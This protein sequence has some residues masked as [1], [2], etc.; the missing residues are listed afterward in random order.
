[1]GCMLELTHPKVATHELVGELLD[2]CGWLADGQST[3][4]AFR[5]TVVAFEARKHQRLGYTLSSALAP[6]GLVQ[7]TLRHAA[8]GDLC[9]SLEVDPATGEMVVQQAWA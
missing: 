8:S 4:D 1:M 5:R 9:A 7:F 2:V 6:Q 3:P